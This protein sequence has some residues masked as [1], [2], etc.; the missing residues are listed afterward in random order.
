MIYEA[1]AGCVTE[2]FHVSSDSRTR[3]NA[4]RS[5]HLILA[6]GNPGALSFYLPFLEHLHEGLEKSFGSDSTLVGCHGCSHA[7]HGF[8]DEHDDDDL[9]FLAKE[10]DFL[11]QIEHF[12]A[13]CEMILARDRD[14]LG[15]DDIKLI[16]VGHSI[17]AYMVIDVLSRNERLRQHTV[18]LEILMPF[19][20]WSNL[21]LA[22][23]TKLRFYL[24]TPDSISKW[25]GSKVYQMQS[26]LKEHSKTRLI[27]SSHPEMDVD[28]VDVTANIMLSGRL[29]ANFFSM[30]RSELQAVI[31]NEERITMVLKQLSGRMTIFALY[32]DADVWAPE[33]DLFRIST[34]IPYM[35]TTFIPGLTHAFATSL[36]K[37]KVVANAMLERSLSVCRGLQQSHETK[38]TEMISMMSKL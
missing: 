29:I 12:E 34:S 24:N 9:S 1:V 38:N 30:A 3:A 4:T 15:V 16:L 5:I 13:F 6:P 19:I 25:L 22:H 18:A 21:N 17:G 35:T 28:A 36:E 37:T 27:Q 32:T 11:E 14:Q 26:Q 8:R 33:R 20:W 31:A 23:R 10:Y 7:N 2:T